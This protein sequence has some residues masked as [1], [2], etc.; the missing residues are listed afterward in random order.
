MSLLLMGNQI[1]LRNVRVFCLWP[2]GEQILHVLVFVMVDEVNG[3][4]N[5]S[6]RNKVGKVYRKI[7]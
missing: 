6:L 2:D 1:Q 3:S 7:S 4:L 5:S